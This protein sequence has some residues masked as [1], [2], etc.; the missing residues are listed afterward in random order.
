MGNQT[1]GNIL[2]W[3]PAHYACFLNVKSACLVPLAAA[4]CGLMDYDATT[5][6]LPAP[7]QRNVVCALDGPYQEAL[8]RVASACVAWPLDQVIGTATV[9]G[10]TRDL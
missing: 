3:L 10:R 7:P 5:S 4:H 8:W 9:A 6:A 2:R 1:L